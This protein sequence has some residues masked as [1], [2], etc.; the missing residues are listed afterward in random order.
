MGEALARAAVRLP[1]SAGETVTYERGRLSVT[2][3]DAIPGMRRSR[4]EPF[5]G[6][7]RVQRDEEPLDFV[8]RAAAIV[9]NDEAVDPQ[10]G[11]RITFE[12]ATWEVRARD[13]EPCFRLSDPAGNLLRIHTIRV[14]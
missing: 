5:A 3:T 13:G 2:I 6:D 10:K 4:R 7:E 14:A 9:L 8:I 11:D 1:A 12:D